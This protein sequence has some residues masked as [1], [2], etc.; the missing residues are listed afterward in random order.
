METN[1][2]LIK[3]F[4]EYRKANSWVESTLKNDKYALIRLCKFTNNKPLRKINENDTIAFIN[5]LNKLGTKSE[6]AQKLILFFRWLHKNKRKERPKNMEWFEFP[7]KDKMI[8]HSDPDKQKHLITDEEYKKIIQFSMRN[9][10]WSAIYEMLYL[11]GARPDEIAKMNYE[12]ININEKGEVTITI[13]H[14]KKI[15]RQVFLMGNPEQIIRWYNQH[16]IKEKN[17]PLFPSDN[18]KRYMQH[19][20]DG[21]IRTNFRR[22]QKQIDIKKTLNPKDFR[23]IRA[24]IM[25]NQRSKDGGLI[26]DDDH[27]GSY[28]GW[29]PSTVS[30]RR[31]EY[32]LNGFEELKN[33][34][35]DFIPKSETFDTIKQERDLLQKKQN[36]ID[37]L[38]KTQEELKEQMKK[39]E[40]YVSKLLSEREE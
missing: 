20:I 5:S 6:N 4:I 28:M 1:E 19:M 32:N 33:L 38:K 34:I 14:S 29:K 23:K 17:T 35:R 39:F 13:N 27:I 12:D 37:E 22:M 36:E 10:K 18:N 7:S 2:E 21:A 3:N 24:T 8:K 11:S 30:Q 9:P 31:Q 25:F 15:P 40:N 16:P 26:F